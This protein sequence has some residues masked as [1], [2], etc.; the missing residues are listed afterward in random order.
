MCGPGTNGNE[1]QRGCGWPRVCNVRSLRYTPIYLLFTLLVQGLLNFL[2]YGLNDSLKQAWLQVGS[3][4]VG[5]VLLPYRRLDL[6]SQNVG[7]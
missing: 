4:T 1:G 3:L 7:L 2:W 5:T 6:R